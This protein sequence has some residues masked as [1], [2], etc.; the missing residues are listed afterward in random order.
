MSVW[1]YGRKCA[2]MTEEKTSGGKIRMKDKEFENDEEY[3]EQDDLKSSVISTLL[4]VA[5]IIAIIIAV[6]SFF[7]IPYD[8]NMKLYSGALV[9]YYA[10]Q[11]QYNS[12]RTAFDAENAKL[13]SRIS[14]LESLINSGRKPYDEQVLA[15]A[16]S[17]ADKVR[18]GMKKAPE[19]SFE[20]AGYSNTDFSMFEVNEL[21]AQLRS[22]LTDTTRISAEAAAIA[23]P[24]YSS[25]E[26]ELA[27]ASAALD[28]SI[29]QN[30]QI[31]NPSAE[32]VIERLTG[33]PGINTISAVTPDHDPNG[34]LGIPGGYTGEVFFDHINANNG[35][36]SN[37]DPVDAGAEGGGAVDIYANVEDAEARCKEL[38]GYGTRYTMCGTVVI[39]LS[40]RMTAPQQN[41]IESLVVNALLK[42]E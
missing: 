13:E 23:P 15:D 36:D 10:A 38:D 1:I 8:S 39:R 34:K 26:A 25:A 5:I 2:I 37:E 11:E 29:K 4:I 9:N 21:K 18:S 32:F 28:L 24:D 7:K 22:M 30:E 20:P 12:A 3:G 17:C 14:E 41:T 40:S 6:I 35:Q 19:L 31:T 16:K 27:A 33:I 42:V